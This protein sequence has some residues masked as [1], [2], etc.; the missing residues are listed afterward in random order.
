MLLRPFCP[1]NWLFASAPPVDTGGQTNWPPV[2]PHTD[3]LHTITFSVTKFTRTYKTFSK[4]LGIRRTQFVVNTLIR[5]LSLTCKKFSRV[6]KDRIFIKPSSASSLRNTEEHFHVLYFFSFTFR[7]M[8]E[9]KNIFMSF[10]IFSVLN[11]VR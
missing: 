7:K 8:V 1:G 5:I 6:T 4:F 9:R 11:F 3:P 2:L 10:R